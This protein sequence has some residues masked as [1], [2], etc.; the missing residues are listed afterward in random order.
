MAN[1]SIFGERVARLRKPPLQSDRLATNKVAIVTPSWVLKKPSNELDNLSTLKST[2]E[3][4][5]KVVKR[6]VVRRVKKK[7]EEPVV[8]KPKVIPNLPDKILWYIFDLLDYKNQCKSEAICRHWQRLIRQKQRREIKELSVEMVS[9]NHYLNAYF[10]V[11]IHNT[12]ITAK[13][14]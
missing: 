11:G 9:L 8:Y 6:K 13:S 12:H 4:P 10:L 7:V 2:N 1:F 5:K 3:K 14:V